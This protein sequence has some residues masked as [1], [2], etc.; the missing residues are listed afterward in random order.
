MGRARSWR[1]AHDDVP[2]DLDR[3]VRWERVIRF[4][5]TETPSPT[6]SAN[7]EG[8]ATGSEPPA[9]M[10]AAELDP[11]SLSAPEVRF[12]PLLLRLGISL[13]VAGIFVWMLHAAAMPLV[14]PRDVWSAG[15]LLE[16]GFDAWLAGQRAKGKM[17]RVPDPFPDGA[18]FSPGRALPAVAAGRPG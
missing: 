17:T 2:S 4:A 9:S 5:V 7:G 15:G 13:L 6:S 8:T 14:P 3:R 12:G 16:S 11:L 1:G 10:P 18:A